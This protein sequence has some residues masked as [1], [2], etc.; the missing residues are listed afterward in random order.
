MSVERITLD[1][2]ILIYAM[3][4]DSGKRHG[5][6][7]KVLEKALTCDCLLTLQVLAEFFNVLTR[8]NNMPIKA[9]SEKIEEFMELF[10]VVVAKQ[11]CL[12]QAMTA[13]NELSMS[14]WDAMLW[15]TARDAGVTIL[16][17]ED[18]QHEQLIKKVRI[19]NPFLPNNYWTV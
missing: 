12:K 18:F 14:F 15:A 13:V 19:V 17:S 10:P 11:N 6:A 9:A 5:M 3:D 7:I 2:N 1:T 16:L 4:V 8:K